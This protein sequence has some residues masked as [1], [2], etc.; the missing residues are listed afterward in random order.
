M[1]KDHQAG[2]KLLYRSKNFLCLAGTYKQARLRR[3]ACAGNRDNRY[4]PGRTH[5]FSEF[6]QIL[7]VFTAGEVHMDQYGPFT[8][9][10]AFEQTDTPLHGFANQ[11]LP[12][13]SPLSSSCSPPGIRTL[14]A[15]TTV[16]IACL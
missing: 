13:C 7:A 12:G 2:I 1:I 11:A 10:R 8:T 9:I 3:V 5:Q 14:R 16:E 4:R 6:L 15:G